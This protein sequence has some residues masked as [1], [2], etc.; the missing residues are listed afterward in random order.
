MPPAGL[1]SIALQ[2]DLHR[3]DLNALLAK[4]GPQTAGSRSLTEYVTVSEL[5]TKLA[6]N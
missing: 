4:I 3:R 2:L 5:S 1:G 6:K